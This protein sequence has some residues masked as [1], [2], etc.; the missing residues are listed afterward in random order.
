MSKF[1]VG[2]GFKVVKNNRNSHGFL[3]GYSVSLSYDDGSDRVRFIDER[4]FSYW[5]YWTDV[6]P[7]N[8]YQTSNRNKLREHIKSLGFS[9]IDLSVA[10][11]FNKT[12]FGSETGESRFNSRGDISDDRLLEL[13]LK[14]FEAKK[15]L[16][17]KSI[18]KL[19]VDLEVKTT[20][21]SDQS[22]ELIEK[23]PENK[24]E[25]LTAEKPHRLVIW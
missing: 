1:K 14:V 17:P 24:P 11:G 16:S 13:K 2:D 20:F 21:V 8:N 25:K 23:L 6:E 7:L 18:G 3:I 22:K 12:Y 9:A 15:K 5:A 4:G 19:T 10:A